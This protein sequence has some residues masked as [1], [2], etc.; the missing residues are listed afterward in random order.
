MGLQH[1]L[2]TLQVSSFCLGSGIT[3][4]Y[5]RLWITIEIVDDQIN[6]IRKQ[7]CSVVNVAN[8]C[9]VFARTWVVNVSVSTCCSLLVVHGNVSSLHRF[10]H[11]AATRDC[12]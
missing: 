12:H 1:G 6:W 3:R 8:T 9:V 10:M 4:F 7:F 2:L 5:L 11:K